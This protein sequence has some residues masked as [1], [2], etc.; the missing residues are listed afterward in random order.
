M[1]THI[2]S[3]VLFFAVLV[4]PALAQAQ[5]ASLTP[6]QISAVVALLQSFGVG[7]STINNVESALNG[8]TTAPGGQFCHD[9]TSDLRIGMNGSGV[10]ALQT[11]L[12]NDGEA[13]SINGSFDDQTASAVTGFQEKYAGDILTPNNLQYGTGYVGVST[14]TKLNALCGCSNQPTPTPSKPTITT[15]SLPNGTVNTSYSSFITGSSGTLSVT[16]L[17]GG[18]SIIKNLDWQSA[19]ESKLAEITGTPT[20]AGTYPVT[21]TLTSGS[22]TVS[23]TFNLVIA[24]TGSLIITT[25]SM[26]SG[27]VGTSYIF[28]LANSGGTGSYVWSVTGL[29]DGLSVRQPYPANYTGTNFAKTSPVPNQNGMG[30]ALPS[31]PADIEGIPTTAG[32]YPVTVSLTSGTQSTSTRY[33]LVI[34]AAGTNT[35]SITTISLPNGTENIPYS[36]SLAGTGSTG[37]YQWSTSELPLGLTLDSTS[38][39]ITGTPISGTA[40]NYVV[41]TLTSGSQMLSK[42][43]TLVIAPAS[44]ACNQSSVANGTVGAYPSCATICDAGYTL[45]NGSC[46]PSSSPPVIITTSLS[47]GTVGVAYTAPVAGTGPKGAA[48]NYSSWSA[49]GLPDG[50]WI[51]SGGT[52]CP[53]GS[54]VCNSSTTIGGTP[55]VDGTF[56]VTVTLTSGGQTVSKQ[57]SVVIAP[58]GPLTIATTSLPSG[59]VGIPYNASLTSEGYGY[60]CVWSATGLPTGLSIWNGMAY[61]GNGTTN[62][63]TIRTQSCPS[64]PNTINITGTPTTAGTFPVTVT[65]TSG[66][67]TVSKRFNLLIAAASSCYPPSVTNG[68]V[69]PFPSCAITCNSGYTLT[70]GSYCMNI[71]F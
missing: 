56:T 6:N 59:T 16:G 10:T 2:L 7:Q 5:T 40:G 52:T 15:T 11:A 37:S 23:K 22:Q 26:P 39:Q 62:N 67:Q 13:V 38:G 19:L 51:N 1:K 53:T 47:N 21:A 31:S 68:T 14:R 20:T 17:P 27:S 32:T 54:A 12:Q 60:P 33:N 42:Q 8:E 50:M 41:V 43:L 46:V 65:L 61:G 29:P 30:E 44:S 57:F 18:L 25:T 66:G 35:L 71:L 55:T 9:F 4:S 58:S 70:S 48:G 24:P 28:H 64:S 36:A 45:S 49:N 34:A 69:S 63:G 3:A